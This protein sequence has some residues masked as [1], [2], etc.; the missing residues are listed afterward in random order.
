MAARSM[1]PSSLVALRG[2]QDRYTS[3]IGITYPQIFKQD[4]ED[5]KQVMKRE[6]TEIGFR[7]NWILNFKSK[8]N[9]SKEGLNLDTRRLFRRQLKN[10]SLV[11]ELSELLSTMQEQGLNESD[12]S[13]VC[14]VFNF[15]VPKSRKSYDW[16]HTIDCRMRLIIDFLR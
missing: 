6:K 7:E 14:R 5:L 1:P 3:P 16:D 12:A 2:G 13:D 8:K 15:P 9:I 4:L 11:T 10:D